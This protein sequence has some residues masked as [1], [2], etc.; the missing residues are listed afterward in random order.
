MNRY[1]VTTLVAIA[2]AAA[3]ASGPA[4]ADDLATFRGTPFTSSKSRAEVTAELQQFRRQGVNPWAQ[5][6]DQLAGFRSSVTR[7][8][9]T[10]DYLA[11]RDQVD[12][13]TGED[14]GSAYLAQRAVE[15]AAPVL[16]GQARRAE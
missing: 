13:L 15:T 6:F 14:S 10:A 11:N 8:Q 7:A 12:A 2:A 16:A 4:F 1:L 5:N 9:V 3:T